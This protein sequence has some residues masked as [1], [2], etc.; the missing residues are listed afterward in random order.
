MGWLSVGAQLVGKAFT[1]AAEKALKPNEVKLLLWMSL[2]AL[3]ADTP[4]RYFGARESSAFG[5]GRKIPDAPNE[6]DPA[7]EAKHLEREAAFYAV[8]IAVQGLVAAGAIQRLKRG[9]E[10]TRAEFALTYGRE[11]LPLE[12]R[13]FLPLSGVDSLPASGGNSSPQGTT[14]EPQ[15]T[16]QRETPSM[17][18]TSLAP[19]E[20]F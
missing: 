10:G 16:T 11:S 8:K 7:A 17:Q 12:R 9:R 18:R 13:K 4:P 5:L 19:V 14:N 6:L 3:D 2:I 20:N 15:E 1:F